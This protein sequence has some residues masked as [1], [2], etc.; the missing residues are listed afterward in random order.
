MLSARLDKVAR[1]E[2]KSARFEEGRVHLSAEAPRLGAYES[3]LLAFPNGRYDDQVDATS[4]ALHHLTDWLRRVRP[5][6]RRSR[7]SIRGS[8]RRYES[9]PA[10]LAGEPIASVG[11][12]HRVTIENGHRVIHVPASTP[13]PPLD[14]R[15]DAG[16]RTA[17]RVSRNRNRV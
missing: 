8:K 3:E 14:G 9:E 16:G 12:G 6:A 11:E 5:P 10:G 15:E 13:I 17:R 4:Y 1:C 7:E 2:A